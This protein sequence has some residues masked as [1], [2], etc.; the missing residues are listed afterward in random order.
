MSANELRAFENQ[1]GSFSNHMPTANTSAYNPV[2]E[3]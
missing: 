2:V 3:E 1:I